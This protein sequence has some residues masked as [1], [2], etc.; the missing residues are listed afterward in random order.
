[1]PTRRPSSSVTRTAPTLRSRMHLQASLTVACGGS[2]SGS[3]FLTMSDI[4]LI[5]TA[6]F[7]FSWRPPERNVLFCRQI[8]HLHLDSAGVNV[9]IADAFQPREAFFCRFD[10]SFRAAR[11][12]N[13]DRAL[14]AMEKLPVSRD[15]IDEAHAI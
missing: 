4:F 11:P 7:A 9:P 3:W 1:M 13:D 5:A 2:V 8:D 15:I 12:A 14:T 10:R 6:S